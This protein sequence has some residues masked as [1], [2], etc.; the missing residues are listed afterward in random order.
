MSFRGDLLAG[1]V[2]GCLMGSVWLSP[3]AAQIRAMPLNTVVAQPTRPQYGTTEIG[4]LGPGSLPNEISA[5]IGDATFQQYGTAP[6]TAAWQEAASPSTAPLG[7]AGPFLATAPP[8][9]SSAGFWTWQILPDG[10]MYRSYLAGG[11]E[12]RFASHWIHERDQGWL[13]DVTLGGRLGILRYG[14]G[15]A[16][17]PEG[18]Q[19]DVEGAA[20]SRMDLEQGRDLVASDFRFGVPLTVRRGRWEGKFSYYHLS[21]HLG[22]EFIQRTGSARLNF[23]RDSLVLGGAFYLRPEMR[24]YTEAGWSF[25]P[26][27]GSRP[28]EFQFG[29]DWSS[30]EPTGICGSPF[31]AINGELR[32]E[33]DFGGSMTVQTGWQW[34][35]ASAHLL[36]LGMHYFNGKTYQYQFFAEHEEQL[37][38]G[39]WYDY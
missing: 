28:W 34:R 12:P 23:V 32:Q 36:R 11:K 33:V 25:H 27:G 4:R 19:V 2:L 21:S 29:V 20:F 13:W 38:V 6:P 9:A 8:S 26:K 10:L 5:E 22:D 35:G 7:G 30:L 18:W 1:V 14:T 37:G 3:A 24:L 15:D 31:F 16:L 17:Q 39:F